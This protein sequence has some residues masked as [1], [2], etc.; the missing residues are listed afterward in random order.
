MASEQLQAMA[1]DVASLRQRVEQ[2]TAGQEQMARTIARLQAAERD[3]RR[4]RPESSVVMP[5]ASKP[6]ATLP[7]P[8]HTQ[9]L[10]PAAAAAGEPPPPRPPGA[11]R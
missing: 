10:P 5:P 6:L 3:T 11:I 4:R 9:P 2:L 1:Q 8:P 7:P